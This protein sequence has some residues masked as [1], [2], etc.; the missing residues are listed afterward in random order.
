M[1]TYIHSFIHSFFH[2]FFH[3][4]I[5]LIIYI[6]ILPS[7]FYLL[8]YVFYIFLSPSF[9][10]PLYVL[11]AVTALELA[12]LKGQPSNRSLGQP[13]VWGTSDTPRHSLFHHISRSTALRL[14]I[15]GKVNTTTGSIRCPKSGTKLSTH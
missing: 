1:Q 15:P 3:S 9:Y 8:L 2:S 11:D 5:L 6:F 13:C 12:L 14:N 4:F 10:L 7:S